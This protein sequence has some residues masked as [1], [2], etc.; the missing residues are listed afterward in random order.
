[1]NILFRYRFDFVSTSCPRELLPGQYCS[2]CSVLPTTRV[3]HCLLSSGRPQAPSP[4]PPGTCCSSH[5]VSECGFE[6]GARARTT[7]HCDSSLK[8]DVASVG[9][10][11]IRSSGH[12]QYFRWAGRGRAR[13]RGGPHG[14]DWIGTAIRLAAS[15]SLLAPRL[16]RNVNLE[17]AALLLYT[18]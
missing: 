6:L 7:L 4:P 1:M 16:A 14:L 2:F 9:V 18:S 5:L 13:R 12:N 10:W 15:P 17:F 11:L 3:L 8:L